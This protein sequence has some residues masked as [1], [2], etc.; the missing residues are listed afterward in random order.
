[1]RRNG[2]QRP[3]NGMQI[4]TWILLPLL[5][6]HFFMFLTPTLP[7]DLSTPLTI[8]FGVSS[9]LA[10][11]FG[12]VTTKTDSMDHK[13]YLHLNGSPHP[14]AKPD[15][16]EETKYCWVCQTDVCHHSMHCKYCDKCVSNFDHHCMWLNTCIG[17]ANYKTFFQTVLWTLIFVLIHV[18]A[19]CLQLG[20][21][22]VGNEEVKSLANSWFDG[23]GAGI[24]LV[25]FNI[26]F[27]VFTAFTA[28]MVLQ[29]LVFH[30]GLMR[31]GITTYQYI[32]K[33]T[34]KKREKMR[35]INQVREKRAEELQVAGNGMEAFILRMGATPCCIP[36]DPIR[37]LVK[38]EMEQ[39]EDNASKGNDDHSYAEKFDS[40]DGDME[41]ANHAQNVES[42]R[43]FH[44]STTPV[45]GLDTHRSIDSSANGSSN[46]ID[47]AGSS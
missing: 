47:L 8:A 31:Q 44:E 5:L 19:I 26:A 21:Y 28:F 4:T 36:C 22:F 13:L 10:I 9:L 11:I 38:Q 42:P 46:V 2:F 6:T 12:G 25:G 16:E 29:L 3:F 18:A 33:D 37:K 43:S 17:A 39:A 45:Q 40:N 32:L 41:E 15:S 23:A 24:I 7:K 27:L 30:L 14:K 35:F 1:M 34:A 20:L